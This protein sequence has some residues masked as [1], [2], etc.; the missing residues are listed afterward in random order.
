MGNA[1]YSWRCPPGSYEYP[2]EWDQIFHY[3]AVIWAKF[4]GVM[5]LCF[6]IGFIFILWF[7]GCCCVWPNFAQPL[8]DHM[9]VG[10]I[11]QPCCFC[12]HCFNEDDYQIDQFKALPVKKEEPEVVV[13]EDVS[14]PNAWETT[15]DG[16]YLKNEALENSL[17]ESKIQSFHGSKIQS[18]SGST[19]QSAL[20]NERIQNALIQSLSGSRNHSALDNERIQSFNGSRVQS[21]LDNEKIQSL[22]GSRVQSALNNEKIQGFN[23]SR[24]QS[25][26]DNEKIQSFNVSRVQSALDNEKIQ[27]FNGSRVQSAALD[28]EMIP[29]LSSSRVQSALN[30]EK[31]Q[32]SLIHM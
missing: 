26:L 20:D 14:K 15:T 16:N 7:R 3:Y 13:E 23:G 22:S 24:V 31:F 21:A 32:S 6:I 11:K 19:N 8:T 4:I 29:N 17:N 30:D 2:C 18:L 1:P 28:N 25:A 12:V 9:Q 10:V 5:V 27:S